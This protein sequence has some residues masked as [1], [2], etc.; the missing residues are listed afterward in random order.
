MAIT[1][2]PTDGVIGKKQRPKR[3]DIEVYRGDT[4]FFDLVL[5]GQSSKPLDLTG[6]TATAQIKKVTDSSPGETPSLTVNIDPTTGTVS[7]GLTNTGSAALST[8]TVYKY[9]VQLSDGTNTRTFI[10]GTIRVTEDISA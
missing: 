7:I 9:D 3:Y 5:K 10:G 2:Y 4:L 6:W 8:S 1:D